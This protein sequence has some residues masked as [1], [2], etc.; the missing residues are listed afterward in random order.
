MNDSN[1]MRVRAVVLERL[2]ATYGDSAR[3]IAQG[4]MYATSAPATH[5]GAT[6]PVET[7]VFEAETAE[8]KV[9]TLVA[10]QAAHGWSVRK[11]TSDPDDSAREL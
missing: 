7:W 4:Q 3:I 10:S 9:M 5:L 2:R 8:G 1:A 11:I 6:S